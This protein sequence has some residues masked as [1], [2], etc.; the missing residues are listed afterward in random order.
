VFQRQAHG[1]FDW[2]RGYCGFC[3]GCGV[4]NFGA[5]Q[6]D[7]GEDRGGAEGLHRRGKQ[8]GFGDGGGRGGAGEG[9]RTAREKGAREPE[10]N[11]HA[12]G[13]CVVGAGEFVFPGLCAGDFYFGEE[14]ISFGSIAGSRAVC[15]GAVATADTDVAV[16]SD[17]ERCDR[18]AAAGERAG[19]SAE[20]L[21]CDA[22]AEGAPDVFVVR[23]S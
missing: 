21:L 3:A 11:V 15:D 7:W 17:V 2:T 23:E 12:G 10:E 6:E 14:R 20:V 16:E 5:G 4:W 18:T 19:A 13:I 8:V 22:G 1:R 9:N